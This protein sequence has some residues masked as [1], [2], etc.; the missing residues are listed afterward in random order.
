MRGGGGWGR[1]STS[2]WPLPVREVK[3]KRPRSRNAAAAMTCETEE[4]KGVNQMI[5]RA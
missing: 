5:G 2:L 3:V 4:E 1:E